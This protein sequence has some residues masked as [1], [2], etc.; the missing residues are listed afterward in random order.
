[1]PNGASAMPATVTSNDR[2][3]VCRKCGAK[4]RVS[5]ISSAQEAVCGRCKTPLP[6]NTE[7]AAPITVTDVSFGP[8]LERS[9][10]PVLVDL[11]AAWCGPCRMIA[12]TVDALAKELAGRVRV[13][14]LNIDENQQTAARYRVDS[15]PTLLVFHNGEVAKRLVGAKGKA[16]LLQELDEFL[17]TSL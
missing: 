13:A 6:L 10:I 1:M 11:W 16:Q 5:A 2:I 8:L 3:V 9:P 4:N 12:P 14:K 15:I 7:P 17:P